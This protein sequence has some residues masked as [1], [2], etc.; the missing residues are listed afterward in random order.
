MIL[1]SFK[2]ILPEKINDNIFSLIGKD[3]MLI[4]ASDGEKTNAMTASWGGVGV[5]WNKNVVYA[6]IRPQRYTK[7]FV[8]K[9][10]V[11]TLSFFDEA[12]RETLAYFGR[13]SGRDEDK[14]A[15][16]GLE[17]NLIACDGAEG[18]APVFDEARLTLVCRKLYNAPMVK[19]GFVDKSLI[20]KNY[21]LGDFHMVYVGEIIKVLEK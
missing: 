20:D 8:D 17:V 5:L 4:G 7:E 10:D 6:F 3:W 13:V 11:F 12:H 15:K 9:T 19:E 1:Y 2:E 14:I 16:K 21:A 18:L